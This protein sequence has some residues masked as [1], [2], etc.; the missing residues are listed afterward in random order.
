MT[1][2]PSSAAVLFRACIAALQP[3]PQD[4][5]RAARAARMVSRAL[6]GDE[7]DTERHRLIGGFA[8]GTAIRPARSVDVIHILPDWLRAEYRPGPIRLAAL[9]VVLARRLSKDFAMGRTA[10]PFWFSVFAP[11]GTTVRVIPAFEGMTGRYAAPP[12]RPDLPWKTFDPDAEAAR[13]WQADRTTAGKGTHLVM[14]LKAWRRARG[15][16]VRPY[17]LEL[18]A[19]E[20]LLDRASAFVAGSDH[21]GLLAGFF[22]WAGGGRARELLSP[23]AF[24][25][26]LLGTAWRRQAALAG[27]TAE[28]ARELSDRGHTGQ[29]AALWRSILGARFPSTLPETAPHDPASPHRLV[30]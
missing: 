2:D 21:A 7:E 23:C 11:D 28:R 8:K 27:E 13:L 17:A 3:L 16:P 10:D 12:M 18:L 26:V 9:A 4:H 14:L 30:S 24:E 19:G 29:A 20:Y 6:P 22:A 15:V 1:G 25:T 5:D